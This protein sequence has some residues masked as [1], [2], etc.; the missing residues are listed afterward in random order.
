MIDGGHWSVKVQM[1]LEYA[2][3]VVWPMQQRW[4]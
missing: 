1:L 3:R 2:S 4:E